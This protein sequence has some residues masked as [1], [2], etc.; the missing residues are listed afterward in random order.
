MS[1]Y[2]T[3]ISNIVLLSISLNDIFHKYNILYKQNRHEYHDNSIAMLLIF[4]Q[5]RTPVKY[6][7]NNRD[8]IITT[9]TTV[10]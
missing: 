10:L 4:Y 8:N 6:S 5:P 7:S 2:Y 3:N 9:T 1:L